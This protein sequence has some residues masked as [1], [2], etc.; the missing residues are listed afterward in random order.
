MLATN[1]IFSPSAGLAAIARALTRTSGTQVCGEVLRVIAAFCGLILVVLV[2]LAAAAL[3]LS[4]GFFLG[5][6]MVSTPVCARQNYRDPNQTYRYEI[7][8]R[9]SLRTRIGVAPQL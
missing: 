9:P 5:R 6:L 1:A 3:D 7:S 2:L 4:T 8:T